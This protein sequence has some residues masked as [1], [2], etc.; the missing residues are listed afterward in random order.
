[1]QRLTWHIGNRGPSWL[2]DLLFGPEAGLL[3]NR[4]W[5]L[6]ALTI[7]CFSGCSSLRETQEVVAQPFQAT[8]EFAARAS[9][10]IGDS[11]GFDRPLPLQVPGLRS[12]RSVDALTPAK[13]RLASKTPSDQNSRA[14]AGDNKTPK[15]HSV[16]GSPPRVSSPKS[17]A[18]ETPPPPRQIAETSKPGAS[19][20]QPPPNARDVQEHPNNTT[21]NSLRSPSAPAPIAPPEP[22]SVTPEPLSATPEPL[23]ATPEPL[24]AT[25]E[26]SSATLVSA[27]SQIS[28]P[29]D[30]P[31]NVAWCRVR[32][33]NVSS[34][35]LTQVAVTMTTPPVTQ[36]VASVEPPAQQTV[37]TRMDYPAIT[38][39]AP[40][41]EVTFR[42]GI[43]ATDESTR[44]LRIQVRDAQGGSN[45]E[46]QAR[47]QVTIDPV[48][49]P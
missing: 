30:L 22:L 9:D 25:P 49:A 28:P 47:W 34:Q 21:P 35:P 29:A 4:W 8:M 26:P 33:R 18:V 48:D 39:V 5:H 43:V 38:Q 37:R 17:T 2:F 14:I 12:S 20:A 10:Q 24:S 41:E 44:R 31:T 16:T 13:P 42:V 19:V 45:Q 11:L 1:M 7:G 32:L 23:S 36:L 46:V 40:N 3:T 15:A 6:A 27:S